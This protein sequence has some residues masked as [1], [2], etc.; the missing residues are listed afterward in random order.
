MRTMDHIVSMA[1]A[2]RGIEKNQQAGCWKQFLSTVVMVQSACVIS[3]FFCKNTKK[4][5]LTMS[6]TLATNNLTP[7]KTHKMDSIQS[8]SHKKINKI[9]KIKSIFSSRFLCTQARGGTAIIFAAFFLF[10]LKIL[11]VSRFYANFDQRGTMLRKFVLNRW[12]GKS[13]FCDVVKGGD[14]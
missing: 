13:A 7:A 3:S 5:S 8:Q 14:I 9:K 6:I 11:F 12:F 1:A 10:M 4:Q 2:H